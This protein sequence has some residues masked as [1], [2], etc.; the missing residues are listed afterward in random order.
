[1]RISLS[2]QNLE[3]AKYFYEYAGFW[4]RA[5]AALIDGLI[6][7]LF[8]PLTNYLFVLSFNIRSIIPL[9]AYN[10]ILTLIMQYYLII[11]YGGTPG[12]LI[13]QLRTINNSGNYLD[14]TQAFMRSLTYMPYMI[15]FLLQVN[16]AIQ[17]CTCK[18]KSSKYP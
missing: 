14:I 3:S 8:Y 15:Y 1:M 6:S 18:R 12:H 7:L 4:K 16:H 2:V 9:F 5:G 11:R 17:N 10:F 13:M